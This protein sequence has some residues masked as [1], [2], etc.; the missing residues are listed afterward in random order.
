MMIKWN[1][2]NRANTENLHILIYPTF[3]LRHYTYIPTKKAEEADEVNVLFLK[4]SAKIYETRP[5]VPQFS[6][7]LISYFNLNDEVVFHYF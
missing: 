1:E 6:F 7:N 5:N 2:W 4:T 3:R